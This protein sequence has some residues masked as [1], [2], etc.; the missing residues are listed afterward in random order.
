MAAYGLP[1]AYTLFLWWAS[2]GAIL[3]LDGLNRRTFVWSMSGASALFAVSLWGLV[4]SGATPTSG[5][6]YAAFACAILAWGWQ[7][8]SFYMGYVT[9]PRKTACDPDSTGWRQF[10][11]AVRTSLYHELTVC[12]T[13]AIMIALTWGQ[14]NQIGVWTFLVLWW[15]HQSAKLNLYFGMPNLGEE[16]LPP[17][18]RYLTSYMRRKPMNLLFPFSVSVSTV[19]TVLLIQKAV[20]ASATEFE[21]A[22]FTM[23]ATLMSL[24]ILEHWVL[25]APL[26]ANALWGFGVKPLPRPASEPRLASSSSKR[27][28]SD[29]APSL[30]GDGHS[31]PIDAAA[32]YA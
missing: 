22:G 4:V 11:E 8:V 27:G 17:H 5:G 26:P 14:P 31:T 16:M 23:L 7:L 15:M 29:R 21:V 24:A 1:V 10:T 30:D 25:V 19:V 9:G 28:V 13:G 3:Y 2:T 18:L 20:S 12:L 6:A 32:D